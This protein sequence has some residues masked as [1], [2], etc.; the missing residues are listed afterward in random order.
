MVLTVALFVGTIFLFILPILEN[1]MMTDR[2]EM[3]R[4]LTETAW[5]VLESF[6]EKEIGGRLSGQASPPSGRRDFAGAAVRT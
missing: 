2:R 6:R 5:S 4:E 1:R 3:V